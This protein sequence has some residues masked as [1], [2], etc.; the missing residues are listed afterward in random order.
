[1]F[2]HAMRVFFIPLSLV[3][4]V[5][6]AF[7]LDQF[8]AWCQR[9]LPQAGNILT[10]GLILSVP[11]IPAIANYDRCDY[12]NYW[13]AYDHGHNI[14]AGMLPDALVF[15]TGDHNTFP[16]VYLTLVEGVRPDVLVADKYGYVDPAVLRHTAAA[17]G[18]PEPEGKND[19]LGEWLIRAAHRPVYFTALTRPPVDDATFVP[20]GLSY[21][22]LPR[23]KRVDR[24]SCWH[25]ISYRNLRDPAVVDFGASC[26][27]F[28][29]YFFS[30]L[31]ALTLGQR[32]H[33]LKDFATATRHAQG[34]KESFNNV[35]SAL[36]DHGYFA[37][38][39]QYFQEARR[40]D[41]HYLT[42][43]RN[44]ARTFERLGN[45][46]ALRESLYEII[47]INRE[48]DYARRKLQTLGL[49]SPQD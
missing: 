37:E 8:T 44:L 45:R 35:G 43:R 9:S 7:L 40:L 20:V 31:R 48:D 13:Y 30:G 28:D 3:L 23:G 36:A 11:L 14:L 29:H 15:P 38:A 16:L 22:L 6:L 32:D 41:P 49:Q 27:L 47:R 12:S 46:D 34:I 19:V 26:I 18:V 42:P 1:M 5:P 21:H 25:K 39:V 24:E 2:R 17:L 4:V 10:A 33:A